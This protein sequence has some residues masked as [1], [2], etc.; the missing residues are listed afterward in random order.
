MTRDT[1]YCTGFHARAVFAGET[2][3]V[4]GGQKRTS[5][6]RMRSEILGETSVEDDTEPV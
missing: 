2:T 1:D 4:E 3:F 6:L 5:S